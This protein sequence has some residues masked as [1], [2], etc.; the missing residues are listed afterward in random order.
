[1]LI[2]LVRDGKSG[3]GSSRCYLRVS[4]QPF[5]DIR[6]KIKNCSH[7]AQSYYC[8]LSTKKLVLIIQLLST[9]GNALMRKTFHSAQH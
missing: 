2:M 4:A 1:M 6:M 8:K 9:G 3:C 5:F 7:F